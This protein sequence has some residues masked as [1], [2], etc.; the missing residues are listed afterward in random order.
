MNPRTVQIALHI[1]VTV[2]SIF[3]CIPDKSSGQESAFGSFPFPTQQSAGLSLQGTLK[4]R[5]SIK[6][7]FI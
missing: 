3:C 2:H 5:A 6:L 4:N 1:L 7:L